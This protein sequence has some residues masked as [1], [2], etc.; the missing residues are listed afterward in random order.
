MFISVEKNNMIHSQFAIDSG[1]IFGIGG[2]GDGKHVH[3]FVVHFQPYINRN[4]CTHGIIQYAHFY[5][6]KI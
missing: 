1:I 3:V 2:D 4:T 5:Y 6:L